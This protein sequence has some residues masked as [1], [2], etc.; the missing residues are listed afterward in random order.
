MAEYGSGGKYDRIRRTANLDQIRM[1]NKHL[2]EEIAGLR[3]SADTVYLATKD[4]ELGHGY[5]FLAD[6]VARVK[7]AEILLHDARLPRELSVNVMNELNDTFDF[8][9]GSRELTKHCECSK[10]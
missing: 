4:C 2:S 7:D 8:V 1:H 3:E 5:Y 6:A 10:R 9:M